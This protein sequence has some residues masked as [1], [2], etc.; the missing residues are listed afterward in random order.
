VICTEPRAHSSRAS[1]LERLEAAARVREAGEF[2]PTY[3]VSPD[4]L[5]IYSDSDLLSTRRTLPLVSL[6]GR[7]SDVVRVMGAAGDGRLLGRLARGGLVERGDELGG[8]DGGR[9]GC[10]ARCDLDVVR[11]GREGFKELADK[12]KP[13]SKRNLWIQLLLS[14]L[15]LSRSD[16]NSTITLAKVSPIH[17]RRPHPLLSPNPP[18]DS[19][20]LS[21]STDLSNPQQT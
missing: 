3:V 20:S 11:E 10:R 17:H 1:A 14:T 4:T 21:I 2:R 13:H 8:G 16:V 9:H 5:P 15:I 6:E 18:L 7:D 19:F 12:G